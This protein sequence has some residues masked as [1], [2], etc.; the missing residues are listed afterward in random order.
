MWALREIKNQ[1]MGNHTKKF[2]YLHLGTVPTIVAAL[3]EPGASPWW[4]R[5]GATRA[6]WTT[7]NRPSWQPTPWGH[8]TRLLAHLEE[9]VGSATFTCSLLV[10]AVI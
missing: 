3:A 9:M 6:A 7:A 5:R 1:I 10:F 2:L 8:L 4:P